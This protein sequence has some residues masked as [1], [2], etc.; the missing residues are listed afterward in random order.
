MVPAP[1]PP[2]GRKPRTGQKKS[3]TKQGAADSS[4][5]P[6]PRSQQGRPEDNPHFV[7]ITVV[8][9]SCAQ[10]VYWTGEDFGWPLNSKHAC[11]NCC[12]TFKGPPVGLPVHYDER[13]DMFQLWGNFCSFNCCKRYIMDHRRSDTS[14]LIDNL[15]LLG[16]KVHKQNAKLRAAPK[17]YKGFLTAPPKTALEMFGGGLTIEEF[18]RNS[19][20]ITDVLAK[21]PF[22]KMSWPDA[23]LAVKGNSLQKLQGNA[24]E[25]SAASKPFA[26][27]RAA[28]LRKNNTL[29]AF[30]KG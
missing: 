2:C 27:G 4:P 3:P 23:V 24:S 10:R 8:A 28:P 29:D 15:A 17:H 6:K 11:L 30:L 25:K 1:K 22:V 26:V 9:P 20:R 16:I 14:H 19:V 21:E 13:T 5:K 7:Q 12:H 18:R